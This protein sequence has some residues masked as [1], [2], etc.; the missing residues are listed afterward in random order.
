MVVHIV[1]FLHILTALGLFGAVFLSLTTVT[2]HP[3]LQKTL[4]LLSFIA[5]L[6][7]SILIYPKHFTFHTAWIM[8]AYL[9]LG[10]FVCIVLFLNKT[11][12]TMMMY[13][14][15][16]TILLLISHDAVTKSTFLF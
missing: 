5:L 1:K 2:K 11:K 3:F 8:A 15:L 13:I 12:H 7:G 4:L 14:L 9:L 6:S 16:M 10:F